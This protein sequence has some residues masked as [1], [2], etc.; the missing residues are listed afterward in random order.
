MFTARKMVSTCAGV[1]L[2]A[3]RW[4]EWLAARD[5]LF[6]AAPSPSFRT[7]CV[8]ALREVGLF[9]AAM[10]LLAIEAD[11][12]LARGDGFFAVVDELT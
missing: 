6:L 4:P 8:Q 9:D 12:E 11:N 2:L 7:A 3:D 1:A 5:R 10:E